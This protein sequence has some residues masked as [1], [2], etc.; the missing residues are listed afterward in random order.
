MNLKLK[1]VRNI[2]LLPIESEKC[3][4]FLFPF[5]LQCSCSKKMWS[6]MLLISHF[7][8][9]G[10]TLSFLWAHHVFIFS[11]SIYGHYWSFTLEVSITRALTLTRLLISVI[12]SVYSFFLFHSCYAR[13]LTQHDLASDCAV[14]W[15]SNISLWVLF[16]LFLACV[17]SSLNPLC[18]ILPFR[19]SVF[20]ISPLL[21]HTYV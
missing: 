12:F 21:R 2:N 8:P 3:Y 14:L 18:F 19:L 10:L 16:Q 15:L 4:H 17:S 6:R 9:L 1:R 5:L 7:H 13:K 11:W 20:V